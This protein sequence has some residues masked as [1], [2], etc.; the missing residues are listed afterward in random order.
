[1]RDFLR[2]RVPSFTKVLL[3][4]SGPRQLFD[5]FIPF[6]YE[7]YG[8]DV[9]IDLVTCFSGVPEGFRGTVY[10]VADYSGPAARQRLYDELTARGYPLVGIICSANPIMTKWK[11]M[12]AA[13]L[14]SKVF[15]I[16]ENGD[17]FWLD[18]GHWRNILHF[19]L[20]RAGM[21][22]SAAVPTLARL[23]FFPLTLAFLLLY[24]GAVHL[25]RFVRLAVSGPRHQ[26]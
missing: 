19:V 21:T 25:R 10:R 11:W 4:E 20:F 5:R 18:R 16:N 3:V 13:K 17:F 15:V 9:Q 2:R 14:P 6:L 8:Q 24:A 23:L 22:G 1:L 7:R 26:S 12:L